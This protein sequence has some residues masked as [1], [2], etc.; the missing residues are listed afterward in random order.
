M[1]LEIRLVSGN[2]NWLFRF[3]GSRDVITQDEQATQ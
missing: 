3:V 2:S 1:H